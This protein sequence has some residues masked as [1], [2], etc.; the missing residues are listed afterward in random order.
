MYHK[1]HKIDELEMSSMRYDSEATEGAR[2]SNRRFAYVPIRKL[3]GN[4]E[5]TEP[6][7][8]TNSISTEHELISGFPARKYLGIEKVPSAEPK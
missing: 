3:L 4:R 6:T 5:P 1:V 2:I 8:P 7:E